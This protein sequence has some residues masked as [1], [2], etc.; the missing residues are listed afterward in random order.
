[1][2]GVGLAP[3]GGCEQAELLQPLFPRGIQGVLPE[4]EV[5]TDLRRARATQLTAPEILWT[6]RQPRP[7]RT[8]TTGIVCMTAKTYLRRALASFLTPAGKLDRAEEAPQGN[9]TLDC[10]YFD[11]RPSDAGLLAQGRTQRCFLGRAAPTRQLTGR[12][13]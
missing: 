13:T 1:M 6:S 5:E 9:L 4:S 12:G 2:L 3:V 7:V 10:W 8:S 11:R